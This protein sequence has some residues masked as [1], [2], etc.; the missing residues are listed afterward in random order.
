VASSR[1]RPAT[2]KA[3]APP[4]TSRSARLPRPMRPTPV[5]GVA[6]TATAATPERLDPGTVVAAPTGA[7]LVAGGLQ[8]S[9][10]VVPIPLPLRAYPTAQGSATADP[11]LPPV[12]VALATELPVDPVTASPEVELAAA[13]ESPPVAVPMLSP[14]EAD[15]AITCR[16]ASDAGT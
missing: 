14:D 6:T 4:M 8:L 1:R 15:R 10:G 2:V 11:V 12:E 9:V 16:G 7:G 3:I 5:S 13:P